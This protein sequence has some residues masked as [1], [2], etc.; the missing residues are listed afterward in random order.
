MA[1]N[2]YRAGSKLLTAQNTARS[3]PVLEHCGKRKSNEARTVTHKVESQYFLPAYRLRIKG[4]QDATP[5]CIYIT[6]SVTCPFLALTFFQR[7]SWLL[8]GIG[9]R[10]SVFFIL[11]YSVVPN[12]PYKSS[13]WRNSSKFWNYNIHKLCRNSSEYKVNISRLFYVLLMVHPCIIL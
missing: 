1:I 8:E 9:R 4:K 7:L 3:S 13:C 2:F 10:I 12:T 6:V 11:I 5:Q